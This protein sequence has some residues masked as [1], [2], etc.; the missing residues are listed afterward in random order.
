[1]LQ[2]KN[3]AVPRISVFFHKTIALVSTVAS[4]F[5]A[6][7]G[8]AS[9]SPGQLV[10][11]EFRVNTAT[12][13]AQYSPRI[14]M[15]ADGNYVV[16]WVSY[17]Q[18]GSY[19]G[20]YAQRYASN[21]ATL[22]AEIRVNTNTYQH[23][24][25]PSVAMDAN[26]D[27]VVVWESPDGSLLGIYA[28]RYSKDGTPIGS[29]FRVNTSDRDESRP[30]V[31]VNADGK[32][33]VVWEH[34]SAIYAQRYAS[35]GTR[36]GNE[37]RVNTTINDQL[38][39]AVAM[40]AEGGFVV[41][42]TTIGQ[43]DFGGFYKDIH[44]QRFA[45]DGS[46]TGPEFRVN[47]TAENDQVTPAV[48]AD[49][50]GNFIV[51]W[52]SDGS[53]GGVYAQRYSAN[54]VPQGGEFQVNTTIGNGQASPTVAM[55]TDGNFV[56]G[57]MTYD[58]YNAGDIY[59]R[60]Y[61]ANGSAQGSEFRV[62]SMAVGDQGAP[63]IALDAD[64]DIAMAWHS[65]GQDSSS[66]GVYAQRFAGTEPV[67][68]A[69]TK[70]DSPDPV[71]PGGVL[72]YTLR[73]SNNH[74]VM[75]PTGLPAIDSA[76]GTANTIRVIDTLPSG[77]TFNAAS[78]TGW[79]CSYSSGTV[80]CDYAGSLLPMTTSS[81]TVDVTAPASEGSITNTASLSAAQY[82]AAAANNTDSENTSICTNA[83][84]LNF[85]ADQ[86][87]VAEGGSVTI[88]VIRSGGSCKAVSV[89]YAT[90]NGSAQSGSDYT[91]KS[92]ILTWANG[93]SGSKTFTVTTLQ[94]SLDEDAETVNLAL[95]SPTS[96]ATIGTPGNAVLQIND[97]DPAPMVVISSADSVVTE[98][99][100]ASVMLQL[101]A[102]SGRAIVVPFT[103]GG[104]A[105]NG[106][107]YTASASPV[108]VPAGTTSMV[109][110]TIDSSDDALDEDVETVSA[111][112]G[113]STNAS[114]GSDTTYVLSINDDDAPPTIS[115]ST[116]D[117]TTT[118]TSN[119]KTVRVELSAPSA[120]EISVGFNLSGSAALGSD[121]TSTASPITI[122][123]G[124]TSMALATISVSNDALD[125]YDETVVVKLDNL[126]NVTP[127]SDT[128]YTLNITDDDPSPAVSFT[129][130]AQT[131][132]EG[133]G[134]A[135]VT[136]QSSAVSGRAITVPFTRSGS[137]ASPADYGVSAPQITIPAGSLSGS[138][139]VHIV[140]DS[141]IELGEKA[142]FTMGSPV[143]ATSGPTATHTLTIKDNDPVIL[144]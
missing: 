141:N 109:L 51:V 68:L 69:L 127:G 33:V 98:G 104:T 38:Y 12:A 75:A 107:D 132:N 122:A 106:S 30:N 91:A 133:A 125:E 97:D 23:Q 82:D 120:H 18:D 134:S 117:V 101:S 55:D 140:D 73:V 10:G 13:D 137:A 130:A 17:G 72:T 135:T 105:S 43:D 100:N 143:N 92:G 58:Q 16:V 121:Y 52:D 65:S 103:L 112:L 136:A 31:A 138:V 36:I 50:S 95:A 94:D 116:A 119:T 39:P 61:S 57:W 24:R 89:S 4:V 20:V 86:H 9:S 74:A 80:S 56:V 126:V 63:T 139:T 84:T 81:F 85:L 7:P 5:G 54:G 70:T 34:E 6:A 78:G 27:F 64:G 15:D 131:V 1:V 26:G 66:Y 14:A 111:S 142:V 45:P 88:Q 32:F 123:P 53:I 79:T 115:V 47:A 28:Q 96:G 41:V 42:W 87:S 62:N 60:R 67:D 49:L 128:S 35:D 124:I 113:S 2:R 44:S 46:P 40:D 8:F 22:A 83:G 108:T 102:P 90:S 77:M 118:E 25:R 37:F 59:A 99:A 114:L 48:A 21:G 76:I 93:E 129:A 11:V 110:A 144:P 71:L 29:E 19:E 3:T